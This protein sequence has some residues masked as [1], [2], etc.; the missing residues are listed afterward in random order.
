MT[1]TQTDQ[2]TAEL[3]QP[4]IDKRPRT[5]E[6]AKSRTREDLKRKTPP[7]VNVHPNETT[8]SFAIG[9]ADIQKRIR[10]IVNQKTQK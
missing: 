4:I 5:F 8:K 6:E 3:S 2:N 1:E 7:A 10:T 9:M